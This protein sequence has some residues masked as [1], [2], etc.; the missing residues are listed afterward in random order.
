MHHSLLSWCRLVWVVCAN[1]EYHLAAPLRTASWPLSQPQ[2]KKIEGVGGKSSRHEQKKDKRKRDECILGQQGTRI[3]S[4]KRYSSA[5]LAL[6]LPNGG[7]GFGIVSKGITSNARMLRKKCRIIGQTNPKANAGHWLWLVLLC[8]AYPKP[9]L[10][11]PIYFWGDEIGFVRFSK[12]LILFYSS[13]FFVA[14][15]ICNVSCVCLFCLL[16]FSLSELSFGSRI[17]RMKD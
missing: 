17:V 6:V 10:T 3:F 4:T 7:R 1:G 14:V 15:V 13:L 11:I 2:T 8:S 16:F 9:F 5:D 12:H